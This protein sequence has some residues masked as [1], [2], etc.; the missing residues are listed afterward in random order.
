MKSISENDVIN[1]LRGIMNKQNC[2]WQKEDERDEKI[3]RGFKNN[4]YL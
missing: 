1:Q 3:T 4:I 2:G